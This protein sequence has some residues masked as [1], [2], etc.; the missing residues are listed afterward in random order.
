MMAVTGLNNM[1]FLNQ[2]VKPTGGDLKNMNGNIEFGENGVS[3]AVRTSQD[4][5]S[6]KFQL[7]EINSA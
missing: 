6:K 3:P 2:S 7:P 5:N 1:H 4:F